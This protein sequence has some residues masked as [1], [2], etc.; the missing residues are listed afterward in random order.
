MRG[1][2]TVLMNIRSRIY[3]ISAFLITLLSTSCQNEMERQI[4]GE[5]VEGAK[6]LKFDAGRC[7]MN[8]SLYPDYKIS[9]NDSILSLSHPTQSFANYKILKLNAD[10]MVLQELLWRVNYSQWVRINK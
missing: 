9:E 8:D 5:W 10:S 6:S 2:N 4:E 7:I 1:E 3:F